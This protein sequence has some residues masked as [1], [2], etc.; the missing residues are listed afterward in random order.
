MVPN[1]L[2]ATY[3]GNFSLPDC[4]SVKPFFAGVA[5]NHVMAAGFNP[6]TKFC[7]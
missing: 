7:A 1:D 4:H 6:D 5:G 3:K 2:K